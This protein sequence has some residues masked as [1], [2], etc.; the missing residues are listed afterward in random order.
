M[1]FNYVGSTYYTHKL[2]QAFMLFYHKRGIMWVRAWPESTTYTA[3]D[4]RDYPLVSM[5]TNVVFKIP[6]EKGEVRCVG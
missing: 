6:K 4:G 1:A 2:C 5:K 3:P